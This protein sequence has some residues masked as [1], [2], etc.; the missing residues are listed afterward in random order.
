MRNTSCG[1]A[2]IFGNNLPCPWFIAGNVPLKPCSGLVVL[3]RVCPA[4]SWPSLLNSF[5]SQTVFC[6]TEGQRKTLWQIIFMD[7]VLRKSCT[8]TV[9][10]CNRATAQRGLDWQAKKKG[11]WTTTFSVK[12]LQNLNIFKLSSHKCLHALRWP[13]MAEPQAYDCY[14][15]LWSSPSG[16]S[17][18]LNI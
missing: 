17:A 15:Y 8:W 9:T 16:Q 18:L 6:Q 10:D 1:T 7:F 13:E 14:S 3:L 4:D 11:I 5:P 12:W 2:S